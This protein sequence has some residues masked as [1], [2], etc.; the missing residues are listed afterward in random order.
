M[1]WPITGAEYGA[2]GKSTE[3][4]EVVVAQFDGFKTMKDTKSH[5]GSQ[6]MNSS[7]NLRDLSG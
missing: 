1:V 2:A 3:R 4:N 5:E 7:V 6:S